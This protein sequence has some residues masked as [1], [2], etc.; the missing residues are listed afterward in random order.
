MK[1]LKERIRLSGLKQSFIA[2]KVGIGSSHL[3][4]MLNGNAVMSEDI[5]NKINELL[6]L[7]LVD[8]V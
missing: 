4:M 3:T 6:S 5:R 1:Q 2:E 7:Y 8:K